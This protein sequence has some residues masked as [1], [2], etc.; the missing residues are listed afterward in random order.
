MST[1][2]E[3]TF[4]SLDTPTVMSPQLLSAVPGWA[5]EAVKCRAVKNLEQKQDSIPTRHTALSH[6]GDVGKLEL[7]LHAKYGTQIP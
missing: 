4:L 6:V 7:E 3:M 2:R 5:R 1:N